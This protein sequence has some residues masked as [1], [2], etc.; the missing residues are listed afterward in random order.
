MKK[1]FT[2]LSLSAAFLGAKGQSSTVVIS[3]AYGGGG[4]ST[5]TYLYDY[6]ELHNVSNSA[7]VLTGYSI[8]YGSA[9][10]Q[11]GVPASNVF[12]I[13]SGTSIPSGGYLL[14]QFG[15]PGS[16][17]V[18]LPVAADI[19][20]TSIAMS[21]SSGKVA[22]SNQAAALG[23]GATATPCAFPSAS[24]VDAV[25]Y[26][27]TA[28]AEGG[29]SANNNVALVSTQGVV[30][31]SSGC[32]DTDN[33]NADF[34]VVTAPVPRNA[35]SAVVVCGTL[36]I[37]LEYIKGQKGSSSNALNWKVT[38]LSSNITM[39]LERAADTR[40]FKTVST[41]KATQER[42]NQPFDFNDVQPL[43][44]KNYYRLKMIDIDGKIS[45]SP[46]VVV[47]N[48]SNGLVFVGMYP[49]IV[50]GLSTLSVSATKPTAIETRISDMT[51]K[52]IKT[53]KQNIP[54]GSSMITVDC[55]NLAPGVYNLTGISEDAP[56]QTIRF[57]KL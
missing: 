49:S 13:P 12:A 8:Q 31:K 6:V 15:S 43:L 30:R 56:A 2:I 3:Q 16:G 38:C 22:L 14:I 42:C 7:Q 45:Y 34:D 54:S 25:A 46:I 23:C 52:V 18:A 44:G 5:G 27:V 47:I 37:K 4:G 1:F 39:E 35:S 17:G 24:I 20:T 21:G 57:V 28:N 9:T 48:G 51:G 41:I 55:G 36:P 26:G 50:K 53:T 40:N 10:N 19:V 29:I 32:V 11:F 33:N